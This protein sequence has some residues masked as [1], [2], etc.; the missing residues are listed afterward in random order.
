MPRPLGTFEPGWLEISPSW[1]VVSVLSA[2]AQDG[3]I[4]GERVLEAL[5]ELELDPEKP[6]PMLA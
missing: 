2:L 3:E 6:D 4:P 5:R 1:I